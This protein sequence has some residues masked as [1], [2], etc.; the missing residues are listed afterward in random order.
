MK[1]GD[2]VAIHAYKHNGTLYRAWDSSKVVEINDKYVV[3]E[4]NR[5]KVTE[6]DGRK[7]KTKEPALV[8]FY[9]D[10]WFNI[11]VQYKEKV[12]LLL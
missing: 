2:M 7:W 3:L 9:K 11:I 1:K 12:S 4:N 6:I 10:S 5:V 8:F